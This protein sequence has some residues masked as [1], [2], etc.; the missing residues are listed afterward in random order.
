MPPP[1]AP[2]CPAGNR[3]EG[4]LPAITAKACGFISDQAKAKYPFFTRN[5]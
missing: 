4:I 5:D 2:R 1:P 3:K